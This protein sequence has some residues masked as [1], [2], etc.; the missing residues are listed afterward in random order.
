MQ[1]PANR[2]NCKNL[3]IIG[4]L[5][6]ITSE[7]PSFEIDVIKNELVIRL[8]EKFYD[9][10]HKVASRNFSGLRDFEEI[11]DDIFQDTFII[12]IRQIKEFK[13]DKNWAD[14]ECEKML[15]Y[16]LSR[17]ANNLLLNHCKEEK[18]KKEHLNQYK[19]FLKSERRPGQIGKRKYE[20]TYD[21]IKFQEVW[22][23]LPTMAIE[24]LFASLSQ[25][26]LDEE[27]Q[28]HNSDEIIKTLSEKYNVTPNALRKAKQRALAAIKTC[29][30]EK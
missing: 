21:S 2:T 15:L 12:A 29:K 30:L 25:G 23:N 4:L 22:K 26:T 14:Q 3:S 5:L 8:R 28:K 11:V 1:V 7:E 18:E 13:L 27:N 20:P 16:W 19:E 24:I 17:I 6:Q 10:L 9:W